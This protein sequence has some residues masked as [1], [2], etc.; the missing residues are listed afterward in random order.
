MIEFGRKEDSWQKPAGEHSAHR[1]H[2]IQPEEAEASKQP[3][4]QSRRP[5]AKP[6]KLVPG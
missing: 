5:K 4:S 6:A 2:L 1:L 3:I